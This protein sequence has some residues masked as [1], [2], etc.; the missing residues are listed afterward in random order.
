MG[1]A[2]LL[3]VATAVCLL[4]PTLLRISPASAAAATVTVTPN[5]DLQPDRATVNVSGT[6]WPAST[7]IAVCQGLLNGV[8]DTSL[9]CAYTVGTG[10]GAVIVGSTS[11]GTFPDVRPLFFHVDRF[12]YV[13][14]LGRTVDC[15]IE[16]CAIAAAVYG[17]IPNTVV[18]A[19]IT[20]KSALA[21]GRVKRRSDGVIFYDNEYNFTSSENVHR[22]HSIAPGG[23]WT[24][25][26]Q[27]QND[28][29]ATADLT[30]TASPFTTGASQTQFFY[31]YYDVTSVVLGNSGLT[32]P[33]VAPGEVRTFALRL[34][35]PADSAEGDEE[36]AFV[37]FASSGVGTTDGIWL[38]VVVHA[39]GG[40]SDPPR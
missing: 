19:P 34:H 36:M 29:L 3:V 30:V 9:D 32:F 35:A 17:D 12:I 4:G 39:L 2:R 33:A 26:L 22:T 31:G 37:S 28:G 11:T 16:S 20:F 40:G 27:V 10:G 14:S 6:G 24:Y 38:N 21:D 25:A 1:R 5:T 13:P 7:S 8:T 18:Y 23:Y 15:A